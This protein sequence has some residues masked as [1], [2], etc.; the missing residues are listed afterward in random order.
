MY[1]ALDAGC[2]PVLFSFPSQIRGETNWW[3]PNKG[4]GQRDIDPFYSQINH[5]E[6]VVDIPMVPGASVRGVFDRLHLIPDSV[7]KAKQRA[8][9]RIR[10]LLLYDMNGSRPD[11]FTLTLLQLLDL[12]PPAFERSKS[13]RPH[14]MSSILHSLYGQ[15]A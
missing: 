4:P 12:N 6:L 13:P 5:S 11:A 2:V 3:K 1:E 9:E 7:V 15:L 10:H 14:M 8:I